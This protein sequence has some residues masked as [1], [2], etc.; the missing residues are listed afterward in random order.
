MMGGEM[1]EKKSAIFSLAFHHPSCT[2]GFIVFG[3][4]FGTTHNEFILF[5]KTLGRL[6]HV[7]S[8]LNF[9]L[10]SCFEQK[11]WFYTRSSSQCSKRAML[12]CKSAR[13]CWSAL[14]F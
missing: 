11:T 3:D 4:K 1:Q 7:S 13:N 10:T 2:T 14:I 5:V 6:I 12:A 9:T 8:T